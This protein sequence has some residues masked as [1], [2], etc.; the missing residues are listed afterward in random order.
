MIRSRA[1]RFTTR[2]RTTGKAAARHGSISITSPVS[3]LRMWS[4][5]VAVVEGAR[6][7]V[8]ARLRAGP[9]VLPGGGV[10]EPVVVSESF[11]V[12]RL[13]L[14]PEVAAAR[15]LPVQRIA[16]GEH[17]QPEEVVDPARLLQRL[18][19]R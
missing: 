8:E 15:L 5:Q 19:Q 13:V 9:G 7:R 3:N 10:G 16:A 4:W 2:S 14:D 6:F 18:V 12:L 17:G 11:A 1:L